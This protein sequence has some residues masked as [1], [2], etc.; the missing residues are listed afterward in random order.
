MLVK[1]A[2]RK[3]SATHRYVL[4]LL[5]EIVKQ[6]HVRDKIR[7]DGGQISFYC[8]SSVKNEVTN[9]CEGCKA[10]FYASN[11]KQATCSMQCRDMVRRYTKRG[12]PLPKYIVKE[13]GRYDHIAGMDEI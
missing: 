5:D 7:Q 11:E 8:I 9:T 4:G 12:L 3:G 10:E 6:T 1:G 2:I 13:P